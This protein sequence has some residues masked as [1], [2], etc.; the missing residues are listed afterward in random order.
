M[1]HLTRAAREFIP[2]I[3]NTENGYL[4]MLTK[5]D[6]VDDI[7]DLPH[8]NRT[9]IAWSMN[10]EMVSRKFEI[11]A[12]PFE[13]R[14]SAAVKVQKAGYPVRIRLDPIVPF[15]GWEKAYL[16]TIKQIFSK[17]TPERITLGTLILA[18]LISDGNGDRFFVDIHT[19]KF[20]S[21]HGL[22]PWLW[23]CVNG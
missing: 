1:E 9:I 4:F 11:R 22:P 15:E 12:P 13:R 10:N 20:Y 18:P 14:L 23:L 19:D 8:N 16:E 7:L 2:W 17:I 3:G 5:S 6:N 21:V